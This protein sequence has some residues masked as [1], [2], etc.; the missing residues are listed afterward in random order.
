MEGVDDCEDFRLVFRFWKEE[1]AIH[2]RR[3]VT[4]LD[5]CP[6]QVQTELRWEELRNAPETGHGADPACG[7][8]RAPRFGC[9]LRA[10]IAVFVYECISNCNLYL[11][12]ILRE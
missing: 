3:R 10:R 1:R 2:S 8:A 4:R 11:R 9:T 6:R 5:V 7:P 12:F